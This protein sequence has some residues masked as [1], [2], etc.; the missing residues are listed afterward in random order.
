M[1]VGEAWGQNL[2]H[3]R[4]MLHAFPLCLQVVDT[5]GYTSAYYVTL[6]QVS[7]SEDHNDLNFMVQ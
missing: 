6:V 1:V 5:V 4:N 2:G 7:K 3:L